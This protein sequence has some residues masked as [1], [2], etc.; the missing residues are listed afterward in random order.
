MPEVQPVMA[1]MTLMVCFAKSYDNAI[2]LLAQTGR[3]S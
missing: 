2:L 3:W 1:E